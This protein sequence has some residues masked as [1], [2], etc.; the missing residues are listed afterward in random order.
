M[1]GEF[2][3]KIDPTRPKGRNVRTLN[4]NIL[5]KQYN[6]KSH[7]FRNGQFH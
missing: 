4:E 6:I 2:A 1:P 5:E 3:K 7:R